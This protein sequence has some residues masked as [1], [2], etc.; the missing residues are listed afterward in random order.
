[1]TS[2]GRLCVA[3][4]LVLAFASAASATPATTTSQLSLRNGPG[5]HSRIVGAIPRG[6]HVTVL[7]SSSNWCR[8]RWSHRSGYVRCQGLTERRG[9]GTRS[10]RR[11]E[12]SRLRTSEPAEREETSGGGGRAPRQP[13]DAGGTLRRAPAR[14]QQGPGTAAYPDT[15]KSPHSGPKAYQPNVRPVRPVVTPHVS[16]LSPNV[17]IKTAPSVMSPSPSIARPITPQAPIAHPVP[18]PHI[19]PSPGAPAPAAAVKSGG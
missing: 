10:V 6:A 1:M 14:Y 15:P 5:N 16:P 17:G 19:A 3:A 18:P 9:E 13:A 4:A 12:G 11:G 8:V 7:G 2:L